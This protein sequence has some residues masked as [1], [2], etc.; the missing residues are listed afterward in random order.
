MLIAPITKVSSILRQAPAR[1]ALHLTL[2]W[3][4]KLLV[5][6]LATRKLKEL[7]VDRRSN[8]GE[9]SN[10][11]AMASQLIMKHHHTSIVVACPLGTYSELLE[12]REGTNH[13]YLVA[14][15]R[16]SRVLHIDLHHTMTS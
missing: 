1:E 5:T 4:A 11:T 9:A 16:N 6:Q 2:T 8:P 7:G 13:T 12:V 10:S 15:C 14:S 3:F